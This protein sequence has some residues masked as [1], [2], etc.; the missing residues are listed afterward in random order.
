MVQTRR[1]KTANK[2]AVKEIKPE[3]L[4]RK[5]KKSQNNWDRCKDWIQQQKKEKIKVQP[6]ELDS[7]DSDEEQRDLNLAPISVKLHPSKFG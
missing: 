7:N 5:T 6:E 1:S 2:T 3:K 4:V